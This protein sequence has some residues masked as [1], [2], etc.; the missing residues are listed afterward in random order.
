MKRAPF[1]VVLALVVLAWPQLSRAQ[2]A[3]T[4]EAQLRWLDSFAMSGALYY[5]QLEVRGLAPPAPLPSPDRS[6]YPELPAS[7]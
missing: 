1:A 6:P 5:A 3:A 2:G 4:A 7:L